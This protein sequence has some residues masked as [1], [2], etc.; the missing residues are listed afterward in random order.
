MKRTIHG[1]GNCEMLCDFER[2]IVAIYKIVAYQERQTAVCRESRDPIGDIDEYALH[3]VHGFYYADICLAG[4]PAR[5]CV[6]QQERA[7]FGDCSRVRLS[8]HR[9]IHLQPLDHVHIGIRS[10]AEVVIDGLRRLAGPYPFGNR[11]S[12]VHIASHAV[13]RVL[14]DHMVY[15]RDWH[16]GN[17][18]G[19]CSLNMRS[20]ILGMPEDDKHRAGGTQMYWHRNS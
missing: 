16:G 4:G 12:N 13:N 1:V 9:V 15:W 14:D 20:R 8:V 19:L 7:I 3:T 6:W 18:H 10:S 11:C 5:R 2:R 17:V